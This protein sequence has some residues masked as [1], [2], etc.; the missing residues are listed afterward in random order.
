MNIFRQ[1]DIIYYGTKS[2]AETA[3]Q[4]ALV[5]EVMGAALVT[6][7][8]TGG[9]GE[10]SS[11]RNSAHLSFTHDAPKHIPTATNKRPFLGN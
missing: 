8:Q 10:R 3:L 4:E 7:S 1:V 9:S 5:D 11:K 6:Q 2:T